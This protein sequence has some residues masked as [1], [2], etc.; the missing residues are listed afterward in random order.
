M[1][2]LLVVNVGRDTCQACNHNSRRTHLHRERYLRNYQRCLQKGTVYKLRERT[3]ILE[4]HLNFMIFFMH[5]AS[6]SNLTDRLTIYAG[7]A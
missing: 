5:K 1:V 7:R 2:L 6:R 3:K 4:T